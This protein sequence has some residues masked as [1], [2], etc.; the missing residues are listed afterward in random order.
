MANPDHIAQLMKGVVSW[1][2]WRDEN[3]NIVPDLNGVQLTNVDL[4]GVNLAEADLL[5]ANLAVADLTA[6]DLSKAK[7]VGAYLGAATLNGANLFMANLSQANLVRANLIEAELIRASLF[8][9][10]LGWANCSGANLSGTDLRGAT[11]L[12][13]NFTRAQLT[14][15]RV[16]GISAW[17]VKL[18]EAKQ[19]D[20]VITNAEPTVTVDNIEV[21]Q[22]IYLLL[23]NE[24]IRDVIDTIGKKGVLLL[25]RFTEGRMVV[26]ER[27]RDKLRDPASCRW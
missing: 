1:N 13:T 17:D 16:Y 3:P 5:E 10:Y 14:G 8:E 21:A 6:A 12:K 19:Q 24:K 23:H 27:L 20:L 25:G 26:L 22:F 11:L 2:A 7:L 4:R 15:C 9:T 18:E